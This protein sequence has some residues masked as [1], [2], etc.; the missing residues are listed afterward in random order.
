LSQAID[1]LI[2]NAIKYNPVKTHVTVMVSR[3]KM[4]KLTQNNAEDNWV[5]IVFNNR[6]PLIPKEKQPTL[7]QKFGRVETK[8]TQRT[9]GTGLGLYI[10]KQIVELHGGEIG[11]ESSK[12]EG[13]S[14]FITLPMN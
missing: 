2:S 11:L 14:F 12:G 5:T 10:T 8:K 9:K 7:F 3:G 6:G 1:N 13:T 4:Q